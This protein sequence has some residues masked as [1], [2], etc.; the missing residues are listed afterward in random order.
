MIAA[1]PA[2]SQAIRYCTF[3]VAGQYFG[4]PVRAVREVLKAQT[5][6]PVPAV[7]AMLTGIINL[8]GEIVTVVDL[9][10]RLGLPDGE[11]PG[12]MSIVTRT[13][14]DVVSL[15]VDRVGE[16]VELDPADFE[17]P[18]PTVPEEA[19]SI[20]TAVTQLPG[21][22]LQLLD[23]TTLLRDDSGAD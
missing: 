8:R 21:Q 2:D 12:T 9:R 17:P 6:T 5:T 23:E 7:G 3:E 1:E 10:R 15:T 16:V 18:P 19:R 13:A 11:R 22:L 4:L 20:I 14:G